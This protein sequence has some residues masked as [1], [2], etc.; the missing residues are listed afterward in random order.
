MSIAGW[1]CG[2]ELDQELVTLIERAIVTILVQRWL[3]RSGESE[4]ETAV[5]DAEQVPAAA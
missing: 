1:K 4:S 5:T 2:A 3:E